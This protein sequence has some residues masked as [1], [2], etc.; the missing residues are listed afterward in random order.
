VAVFRPWRRHPR[1]L[2]LSRQLRLTATKA[3]TADIG[4]FFA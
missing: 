4:F 1:R 2:V 3:P